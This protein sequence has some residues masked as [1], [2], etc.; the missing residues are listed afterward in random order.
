MI[1]IIA[2]KNNLFYSQDK[3]FFFI[4]YNL[5]LYKMTG[6]S[7]RILYFLNKYYDLDPNDEE[8]IKADDILIQFN[9]YFHLTGT[10]ICNYWC[11]IED[12]RTSTKY[13]DVIVDDDYL[14]GLKLRDID[15]CNTSTPKN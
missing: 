8:G 7:Q 14:F 13:S 3:I 11:L 9:K 10:K 4:F 6:F 2:L 1:Q 5:S 15:N 12:L